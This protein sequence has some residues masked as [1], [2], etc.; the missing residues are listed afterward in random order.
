VFLPWYWFLCRFLF[1]C[2][3]SGQHDSL[4]LIVYSSIWEAAIF[5]TISL[6]LCSLFSYESEKSDLSVCSVFYS[7]LGWNV[8]SKVLLCRVE[9]Q[10]SWCWF[11]S[12]SHCDFWLLCCLIIMLFL[13]I[14]KQIVGRCFKFQ[15]ISCSS[16][17]FHLDSFP[18]DNSC[19]SDL[20]FGGLLWIT[21]F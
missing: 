3:C 11:W 17:N 7:L 9:H 1:M 12:F 8:M 15:Q 5:S 21:I 4:C 10:K 18:I 13:A 16:S 14:N 2:F 20:Y 19:S 6:L